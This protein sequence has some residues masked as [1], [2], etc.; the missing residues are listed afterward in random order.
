MKKDDGWIPL[1][2]MLKFNRLLK[3]ADDPAIISNALQDSLLVH[4]SDDGKKI[5]RNPEVPLP[6]N[7]LEYWQEIKNRTVYV[8][9]AS[10]IK[11]KNLY[12]RIKFYTNN[13][14][15]L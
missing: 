2:T 1:E 7:S 6:D 12:L 3:L 15:F 5:R 8:V 11:S 10:D 13:K 14:F 4:V 9:S